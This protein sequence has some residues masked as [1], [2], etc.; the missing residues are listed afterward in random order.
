[1]TN[2]EKIKT[3]T[4]EQLAHFLSSRI[5]ICRSG[6]DC[7]LCTHYEDVLCHEKSCLWWLQREIEL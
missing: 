2:F 6:L 4:Q 3:M 7:E 1:M 5:K